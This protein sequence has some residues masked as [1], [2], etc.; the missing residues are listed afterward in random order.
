VAERALIFDLKQV[1]RYFSD[2]SLRRAANARIVAKMTADTRVIVAHSL[3]SVVAYETL[4]ANPHWPV[5]TFVHD[6]P[7]ARHRQRDL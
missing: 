7:S 4:W 2:D 5:T 1:A 6:W 3:G